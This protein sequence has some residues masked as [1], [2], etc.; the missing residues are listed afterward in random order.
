MY[1]NKISHKN[2]TFEKPQIIYSIITILLTPNTQ[3]NQK[4]RKYSAFSQIKLFKIR[5]LY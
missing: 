2:K 4:L 3:Q 5:D 1:L